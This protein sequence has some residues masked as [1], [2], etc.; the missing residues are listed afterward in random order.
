MREVQTLEGYYREGCF[1]TYEPIIVPSNGRVLITVFIE[2]NT[3]KKNDTWDKFDKLVDNFDEKPNFDDFPR[4][5]LNR[6]L[7]DF[8]EVSYD[9]RP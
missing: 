6:P 8:N 7:V 4:C 1:H 3:D 9:V 5:D 2:E